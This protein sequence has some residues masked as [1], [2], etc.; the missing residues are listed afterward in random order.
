[1]AIPTYDQLIWPLLQVLRSHPDGIRSKEV[2]ALA[3]EQ[4]GLSAEERA[5]LLPSGKQAIF[6][7]R[8]GWSHDRLK[9]AGLSRSATRGTWCLTPAGRVFAEENR[10]GLSDALLKQLAHVPADSKVSTR[11]IVPSVGS[12]LVAPQDEPLARSPDELIEDAVSELHDSVSSQLLQNIGQSSPEFFEKLVLDLLLAMGYGTSDL[13]VTQTGGTGDGGIDGVI[14]LDRLGLEKVYVQAKRWQD[15]VGRPVIQSFF[16]ALAGRRAT[17]GVFITTS[18]FSKEAIAYAKQAS[19]SLVLMD[20]A[21]LTSLMIEFGVGVSTRRTVH[22][23]DVD[24]DYF[25]EL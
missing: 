18:A 15:A 3:A 4:V 25:D 17:K 10:D 21:T 22:V 6:Q 23:V 9:R 2:N 7:N 14:S 5:K 24:G 13:G 11:S 12:S 8:L 20:G 16:G 1:M 19:D